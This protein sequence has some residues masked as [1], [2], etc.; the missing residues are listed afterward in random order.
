MN[1]KYISVIALLLHSFLLITGCEKNNI[2]IKPGKT[3][4][5]SISEITE[6]VSYIPVILND[7]YMEI[8]AVKAADGTI[9]TAFNTC[10]RCYETGKGYYIQE[11]SLVICQQCQM[12]F[13]IDSIGIQ[14]GGCQP[15]PIFTEDLKITRKSIRIPYQIL[16]ENTHWFL[17]WKAESFSAEEPPH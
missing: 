2:I 16:S 7:I 8:L 4:N 1:N 12:Y 17:N 10:E 9:R 14:A 5:I 3:L 6:N 13:S 11:G 15:I